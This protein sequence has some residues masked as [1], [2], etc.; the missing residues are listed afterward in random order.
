[1]HAATPDVLLA[2]YV[3]LCHLCVLSSPRNIV[4]TCIIRMQQRAL[5]ACTDICPPAAEQ[6]ERSGILDIFAS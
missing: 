2:Q 6:L 4:G 5:K 1:M 3:W